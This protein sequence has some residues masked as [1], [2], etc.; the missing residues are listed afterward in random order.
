MGVRRAFGG[1]SA[2]GIHNSEAIAEHHTQVYAGSPEW[3]A[4]R[5]CS[6][7][8]GEASYSKASSVI[9]KKNI[10][11]AASLY[12]L[13]LSDAYLSFNTTLLS[14]EASYSNSTK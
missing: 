3:K 7:C 2:V 6:S 4:R 12:K 8:R 9:V 11:L 5:G 10:F 13:P 14:T 1:D